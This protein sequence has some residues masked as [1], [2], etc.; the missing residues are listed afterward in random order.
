MSVAGDSGG[1]FRV[2]SYRSEDRPAVRRICAETGFLGSPIDPVFEDRELFADFLTSPYTDAEPE[3]CF[4]L[5][6]P[7]GGIVGYLTSSRNS[8]KRN[9]YLVQ[10]FP[11]WLWRALRGMLGHYQPS[12]RNYLWWLFLRG[13]RETPS[14][15]RDAA[16]FHINLLPEARSVEA[17]RTVVDR[18]LVAMR[19]QGV[20]CVYAQ[21]VT[22]GDRRGERM[23][24][25]YGFRVTDRRQVTKFQ[26]H[27]AEPVTLCTVVKDLAESP[28]LYGKDL[29]REGGRKYG[30]GDRK[31]L[32]SLHDFH[33]G[34]RKAIGEQLKFCL[35][36]CPGHASILVI[37][38]YH[39]GK[40]VESCSASL[41]E[42]EAWQ[43]SGH[44]L[45]VHGYFHDRKGL[46]DD[47]WFWT[48]IYTNQEAEFYRLDPTQAE[49]RLDRSLGIW[50]RQ[51]WAA[52]GFVAPGWLLASSFEPVLRRKGF[53][54]TCRLTDVLHLADGR[55]D[56]AWAGTYSLR[57]GWRRELAKRWHPIWKALWAGKPLVRLSLHPGDLEAPFVRQQVGAL[58]E[59]LS[60][61]GYRSVSYAEHVQV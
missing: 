16:H 40:S 43:S 21:V 47:S 45:A 44:D 9:R 53:V 39:H 19:E 46:P 34:S 49:L 33:P 37:P 58:L 8:R 13:P 7:A 50:R 4:V 14:A 24:A 30:R 48:R 32:L 52:K 54:Y 27:S 23:F 26:D 31:L 25:R 35:Q 57:S 18:F 42:L 10:H 55:R 6:G 5:E 61:R 60:S 15:P 36:R 20:R 28:L 3:N 22:H 51:G 56:R 29:H 41:R 2:R 12:S 59:E 17:V 11:K 1:R 38:E